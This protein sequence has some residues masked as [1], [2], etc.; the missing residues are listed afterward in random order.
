MYKDIIIRHL[1]RYREDAQR[2]KNIFKVKAYDK[3]LKSIQELSDPI[4]TEDDLTKYKGIGKSIRAKILE[5]MQQ[6]PD[7]NL[8]KLTNADNQIQAIESFQKI[9]GIGP[10][11]ARELVEDHGIM[12]IDDLKNNKQLL[13]SKQLMGL[14]YFEDF[15]KRIP[16]LEMDKHKRIIDD[17]INGLCVY[18]IA[19]S[20]RRGAK[21]SGDI[22]VLVTGPD[23]NILN[24]IIDRL[25]KANYLKDD[26]ALGSSKYNGVSKLPRHKTYRRI[27]IMYTDEQTY[28][29]ALMYFTGSK[30]FNVKIRNIALEKGLSL[31]EYGFSKEKNK[32]KQEKL[33]IPEIK[34]EKDIFEYLKIPYVSPNERK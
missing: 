26:F 7:E 8:A 2:E 27:D 28:P 9:H 30:D 24:T 32:K 33:V 13:N 31:N 17:A 14:K 1:K 4:N 10:V 20:Y 12:T 11:K 15:E 19:G 34:E 22:D 23:P 25:K 16:R 5:I 21:D 3:V 18:D 29:F 6:S